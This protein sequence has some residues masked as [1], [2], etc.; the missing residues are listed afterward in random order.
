MMKYSDMTPSQF[1]LSF[2]NTKTQL[3]SF[4]TKANDMNSIS[5][6]IKKIEKENEFLRKEN[7]YF[8]EVLDSNSNH[9]IFSPYSKCRVKLTYGG[10]ET[11]NNYL[12]D[13][14]KK[15]ENNLIGDYTDDYG[16]FNEDDFEK[17]LE[18]YKNNLPQRYKI[19]SKGEYFEDDFDFIITIFMKHMV[20]NK[21]S[22]G[23][24]YCYVGDGNEDRCFFEIINDEE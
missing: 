18:E 13:Y 5:E 6:N 19:Y 21:I 4:V 23:E 1:L 11:V 10:A 15:V 24:I 12:Y 22:F 14:K 20:Y 2:E 17:E 3:K 7:K 16:N 9:L 8:H